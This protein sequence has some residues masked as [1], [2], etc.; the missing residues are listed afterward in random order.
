MDG[1]SVFAERD[2]IKASL[3]ESLKRAY[4]SGI[5]YAEKNRAYRIA[6]AQQILKLKAEGMQISI[7]EKV[8]RGDEDVAQAEFD[9]ISAEVSYR[10]SNENIMA[11]KKELES[12]EADIKREFYSG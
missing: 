11:K 6:L 2:K 7:I 8:A 12:V 10:A 5:K 4:D 9:M 3:N 1:Q